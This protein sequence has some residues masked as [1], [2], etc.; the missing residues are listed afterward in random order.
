MSKYFMGLDGSTQSLTATIIDFETKK[1]VYE[2]SIN[3]EETLGAKYAVKSGTLENRNP[4]VVHSSPKMWLE[5]VDILFSKMRD[6]GAPLSKVL[7]ISGSGQQHGSVYLTE[8]FPPYLS[9]IK[10]KNSLTYSADEIFSRK[11]SPIWMDSSTEEECEEIRKAL[12]GMKNVL[13]L[14][15]SDVFARFTAPQIRKFFKEDKEGYERTFRI[16]LVSSFLASVISGIDCPIDT[17]DG[18]GMSLMDIE[19]L[20]WD[21][22]ALNATAPNLKSKLPHVVKSDTC[23]GNVNAYFVEK[24][25]M[26]EKAKVIVFSGD[27]PNSLIGVGL[28]GEG[29]AAYSLGTSDVFMS[30][31]QKLRVNENGEGHIFGSPT[32]DY[33][34]LLVYKNGSLAREKVRD[35]YKLDWK[36]FTDCLINTKPGNDGGLMLPYFYPEIIPVITNPNVMRFNLDEKDAAKNV[37]GVI[38]AQMLSSKIHSDWMGVKTN[39]IYATGGASKDKEI[40]R[41]M[42]NVHNASVCSFESTS[43]AS[44]GAAIRALHG[45]YK[46]ENKEISWNVAIE[47]FI[48]IDEK[49]KV[50]PDTEAVKIYN[51]MA[52]KYKEC[53]NMFL[54]GKL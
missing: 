14:T 2:K 31:M 25:G 27:N 46:S 35:T 43:S 52:Q 29:Q 36:T 51:E 24:Y 37:R 48:K 5:S 45:Y 16:H 39:V 40:R 19:K 15:G 50:I 7:A 33:M 44:L 26:N 49:N 32:G 12:G 53:E 20:S 8:K 41:V 42:A 47:G 34:T 22:K 3:F 38:E 10:D 13:K 21:E 4:L 11:T 9:S 18:A 28:I 54:S 23:I 30:V 17:G 6:E 1:T